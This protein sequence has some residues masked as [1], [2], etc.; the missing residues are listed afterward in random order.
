MLTTACM[1]IL[2]TAT[3]T[4]PDPG[5]GP[6]LMLAKQPWLENQLKL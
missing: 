1:W 6:P 4:G 5:P 2:A 3:A